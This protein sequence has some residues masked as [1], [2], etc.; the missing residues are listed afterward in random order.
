MKSCPWIIF[1]LAAFLLVGLSLALGSA[2]R[3]AAPSVSHTMLTITS[4]P[5]V[6]PEPFWVEPL[7]SP[8]DQIS[9]VVT[10]YL[11]HG[12]R[13]TITTKSGVFTADGQIDAYTHPALIPVDLL[14]NT[15]H[16]LEA[17]GQVRVITQGNCV[18]GGYTL[19]RTVD[20]HG[21]PL[22]IEQWSDLI[23]VYLPV[24][25]RD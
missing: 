7:T 18:Y 25:L 19:R 11:G 21:A 24:V 20:R 4:C 14:T 3:S 22:I 10:V 15:T 17:L 23:R 5:S 9:Q 13:V 8:T 12:E 16:S 1:A 6:T 2:A